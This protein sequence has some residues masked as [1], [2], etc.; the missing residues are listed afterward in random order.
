MLKYINLNVAYTNMEKLVFYR[1]FRDG[2]NKI[3]LYL[4]INEEIGI[5]ACMRYSIEQF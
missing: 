1:R 2:I 4:P 3:L 5:Y